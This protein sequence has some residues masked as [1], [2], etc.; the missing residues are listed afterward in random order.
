[1]PTVYQNP[2]L[3]FLTPESYRKVES[4]SPQVCVIGC[5]VDL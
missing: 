5:K 4:L 1:M 2:D 3:D